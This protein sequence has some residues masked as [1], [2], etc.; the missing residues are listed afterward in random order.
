MEHSD[1]KWVIQKTL[2]G[3]ETL[4]SLINAVMQNNA[5]VELIEVIPFDSDIQYEPSDDKHPIVYGSS[6]FMFGSHR[7]PFLKK[8]VFYNPETFMMSKYL[9]QWGS[10]ML[11]SDAIVLQTAWL[12]DLDWTPD[13]PVFIRPDDDSKS[14]SGMVCGYNEVVERFSRLD[15][16]NPY[17]NAESK[18]VVSSVKD[19]E[20]E[21]RCFIIQ[22]RVICASR[23]RIHGQTLVDETDNPESMIVFV[24]DVCKVFVPHDVFVIDVA[25]F[26]GNYK[27]VECNCFNGSGTYR[28]DWN[29]IVKA[30]QEFIIS[31]H[32]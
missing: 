25:L 2:A 19:V 8:G 14:F 9:Q 11:N 23:Y 24:E 31:N 22:G 30:L 15:N 29:I 3:Q 20:R 18:V 5:T 21:W 4:R 27:I 32:Q 1:F 6:T 26:Q 10:H 7:H 28:H 13:R 12:S 17:L 16:S